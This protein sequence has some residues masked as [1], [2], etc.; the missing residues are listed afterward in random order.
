[1]EG[2]KPVKKS[3]NGSFEVVFIENR[4]KLLNYELLG[5]SAF[6]SAKGDKVDAG[7]FASQIEFVV[8]SL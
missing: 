2:K 8:R 4:K 7:R 5:G 6:G 1:M 3:E